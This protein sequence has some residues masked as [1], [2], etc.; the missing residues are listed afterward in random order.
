MTSLSMQNK[1]KHAPNTFTVLLE[2]TYLRGNS[3]Q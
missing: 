3:F 1:S 2:L